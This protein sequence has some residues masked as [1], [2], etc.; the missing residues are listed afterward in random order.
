MIICDRDHCIASAGIPRR[1]VIERRLTPYVE[2]LMEERKLFSSEID[3]EPLYPLEGVDRAMQLLAPIVSNGDVN[4][5]VIL[6][7]SNENTV[8]SKDDEKLINTVASFLGKQME[9]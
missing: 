9:S 7:D 4:G 2:Q 8:F 6:L 3:S 1:E 5:A